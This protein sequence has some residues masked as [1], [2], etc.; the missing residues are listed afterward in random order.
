[1]AR[2]PW[3]TSDALIDAVKRKISF[4]TH[5]NTFSEDD[6]LAFANEEMAVAQ[7]PGV[8]SYHDEY[9]VTTKTVALEANKSR[10]P[11]PDR[12]IGLKLRD[13]F[14]LDANGNLVEMTRIAPD[15]RAVYQTSGAV[16]NYYKFYLEGNDIVLVPSVGSSASGS[17]V[18]SYY[19]RPN[20]LVQN[21]EAAI[22]SSF[23]D[24]ITIDNSQIAAGD[25]LTV[26]GISFTARA[27]GAVTNEFNIG[28]SSSATA[29]NLAAA[30][31]T[32][33]VVVASTSGTAVVTLISSTRNLVLTTSNASGIT[34]ATTKG[35][36]CAS[37]PSTM[38]GG[39]VV[40][41]LQTK[42][43]HKTLGLDITIPAG[44][45]SSTDIFLNT[46]DV[47][48]DVIVGDYICLSNECII[49]QIPTDLHS[50]L[51]EKVCARI[52]AAI[53]D[54]DGLSVANAKI[55]ENMEFEGTL[56]DNRVEGAPIKVVANKSLLKLGKFRR[57]F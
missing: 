29:A 24:L 54:K 30:I 3:L 52:L 46:T 25:I 12:A 17:L 4:P 51:A 31:T 11:I 32:N 48:V 14:Y 18:F 8:L 5:E 57:R 50:G 6:I 43:G 26:Q 56:L 9:F 42:P 34:L 10:Y 44:G 39:T 27:S 37:V 47:S 16:S 55:K 41:L 7:V 21:A 2:T 13:L 35:V 53:G 40:D 49:P 23:L 33:G 38:T 1:M 36:R 20:Q 22:I 15:E 28:G 45:A 19:L